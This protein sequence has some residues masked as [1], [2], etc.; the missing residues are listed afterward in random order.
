M[1]KCLV[2]EEKK[3]IESYIDKISKE[4][5]YEIIKY[6]YKEDNI[7]EIINELSY[8]LFFGNKK[9]VIINDASFLQ[10]KE[11]NKLE[12]IIINTNDIDIILICNGKLS[13][14]NGLVNYLKK[15]NL[16]IEF[17]KLTK[18]NMENQIRKDFE[19][20]NYNIDN[21]TIKEIIKICGS[22]YL[23][24]SNEIEKLK[25]Y[26]INDKKITID[27]V[28]L[29]VSNNNEDI[30]YKFVDAINEKNTKQ[31]VDYYN[32]LISENNDPLYL[33]SM[34]ASNFR[35]LL[36]IKLLLE[37]NKKIQEIEKILSVNKYRLDIM[38]KKS[39]KLTKEELI[40]SLSNLFDL[41][42]E[43]KSGTQDKNSLILIFLLSNYS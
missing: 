13:D 11:K 9:L 37:D 8:S 42:Y 32:I 15:N 18:Y 6:D 4:N 25:I 3:L 21:F 1:I 39:Y 24:I 23:V 30:I 20:D 22:E 2:G 26:K 40:N 36:Q 35:L 33:I 29:I 19:L 12:D 16:I 10:V 38:V 43:I 34:L 31:I 41:E 5:E 7:N 17:L 28:H 14:K 27:D